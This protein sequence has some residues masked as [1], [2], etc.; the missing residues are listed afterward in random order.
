ML[1]KKWALSERLFSPFR[2]VVSH[3][4]PTTSLWWLKISMMLSLSLSWMILKC[5]FSSV[6]CCLFVIFSSP[7]ILL[8]QC[9]KLS[10]T[11]PQ[12]LTWG[13][14]P[15]TYAAVCSLFLSGFFP[16]HSNHVL[17]GLDNSKTFFKEIYLATG[18]MVQKESKVI[19]Q[20]IIIRYQIT[21]V[22]DHAV[23]LGLV[24]QIL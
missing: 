6:L 2:L 11:Q 23:C 21:A 13:N 3:G 16:H 18:H 12:R 1:L 10:L 24:T 22:Q 15:P 4:P 19:G 20:F 9:L 17:C 14:L 8:S 7:P 5:C